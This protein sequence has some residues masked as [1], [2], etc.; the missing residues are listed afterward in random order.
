MTTWCWSPVCIWTKM[1]KIIFQKLKGKA[2]TIQSQKLLRIFWG[3]FHQIVFSRMIYEEWEVGLIPCWFVKITWI[4]NDKGWASGSCML[5]VKRPNVSSF[6][7]KIYVTVGDINP[8]TIM[9]IVHRVSPPTIPLIGTMLTEFSYNSVMLSM[10][11]APSV[12][13]LAKL[14]KSTH[15]QTKVLVSPGQFFFF[16]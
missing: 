11:S 16:T 13:Y 14:H 15:I 2:L 4:F 8:F 12:G 9:V 5:M 3:R 6:K 7:K 10:Y 1:M